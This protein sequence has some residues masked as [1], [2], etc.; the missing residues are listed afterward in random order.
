MGFR[1]RSVPSGPIAGLLILAVQRVA[2]RDA[3]AAN[4]DEGTRLR[5]E[6]VG[7]QEVPVIFAAGKA[8]FEMRVWTTTR[9][10]FRLICENLTAPPHVRLQPRTSRYQ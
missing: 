1:K 9:I 3:F 7:T 10:A 5:A 6:P 4:A 8:I 2:A